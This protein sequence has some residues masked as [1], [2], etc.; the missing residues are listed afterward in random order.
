MSRIYPLLADL[1]ATE[2]DQPLGDRLED[3]LATF[4]LIQHLAEVVER[5]AHN[6]RL[7]GLHAQGIVPQQIKLELFNHLLIG[8]VVPVFEELQPHK[9][10]HRF[11][12]AT[13]TICKRTSED[14][15][16]DER[17]DLDTKDMCPRSGHPLTL[18][19]RHDEMRFKERLLLVGLAEHRALTRQGG[20]EQDP[21]SPTRCR[22]LRRGLP[23]MVV[24][25]F[26][27]TRQA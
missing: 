4:I 21:R 13:N 20:C 27:H 14:L 22:S 25:G 12:W 5:L 18:S 19:L 24:L 3:L 7:C 26:L 1:D 23:Y 11:V 17:Q 9:L 16:V 8:K 6:R 15:F 2:L 10:L